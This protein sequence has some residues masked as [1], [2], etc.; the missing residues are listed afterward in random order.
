MRSR[1]R[2]STSGSRRCR[3]PVSGAGA[4]SRSRST[5]RF[6]SRPS[7][8]CATQSV[9][10]RALMLG[11]TVALAALCG[12]ASSGTAATPSLDTAR[13][14]ALRSQGS[15]PMRTAAIVLDVRTG[16]PVYAFNST[17]SLLPASVEKLAVSY[18]ALRVLGPRFRFRT[19]LVGVGG[20]TGRVW[21][22]SLGLVGYGDPTLT[23]ADLNRIARRF[24]DTGDRKST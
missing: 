9:V 19:E 20:R 17:A 15:A 24:A 13:G 12:S 18:T 23:P 14:K 2:S 6:A 10:L 11:L 7:A 22:G 21:H 4:P 3:R 8:L 16:T 1:A 5:A